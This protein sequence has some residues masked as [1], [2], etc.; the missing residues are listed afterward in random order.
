[1]ARSP[2]NQDMRQFVTDKGYLLLQM[3]S[4][5]DETMSY[6]KVFL[7]QQELLVVTDVFYNNNMVADVSSLLIMQDQT[8]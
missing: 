8:S 7:A 3:C 6:W 1:M 4:V 5:I 2:E